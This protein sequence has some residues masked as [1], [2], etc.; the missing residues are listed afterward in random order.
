MVLPGIKGEG[1][2]RI[3]LSSMCLGGGDKVEASDGQWR[4]MC[5][6]GHG[7]GHASFTGVTRIPCNQDIP[8]LMRLSHKPN[9]PSVKSQVVLPS[10]FRDLV[11][12]HHAMLMLRCCY[13]GRWYSMVHRS[14]TPG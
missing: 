7:H 5:G 4:P 2:I 9:W 11:E 12:P 14:T 1:S 8:W 3:N 13:T 6:Y 10:C